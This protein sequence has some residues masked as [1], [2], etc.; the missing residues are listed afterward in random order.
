MFQRIKRKM[1]KSRLRRKSSSHLVFSF[2]F[3]TFIIFTI[4]IASC[5]QFSYLDVPSTSSLDISSV[6]ITK[7]GVLSDIH[8]DINATAHFLDVFK[9]EGVDFI[10]VPG[11]IPLNEKLRYGAASV[12][13]GERD[14]EE[15]IFS[16]LK[17]ISGRNFS[18]YVIPGNHESKRAYYGAFS[19]LKE[20]LTNEGY[21]RVKDM[22]YGGK[23]SIY[24]SGN[25]T[26]LFDVLDVVFLPGYYVNVT[27]NHKFL[28]DDGFFLS[29]DDMK[30]YILG[31]NKENIDIIVSHGPPLTNSPKGI[32]VLYSGEHVGSKEMRDLIIANKIPLGIFGHIHEASGGV[33]LETDSGNET[34]EDALAKE[35]KSYPLSSE[36]LWINPGS[37]DEGSAGIVG[38]L[39]GEGKIVL[40]GY[41]LVS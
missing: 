41:D 1:L 30:K 40:L 18:A 15:E 26:E 17:L 31:D 21:D 37:V 19:R 13:N 23:E 38:V 5:T 12:T 34:I 33:I 20:S 24:L 10:I 3:I 11:D 32:D 25:D 14:D 22:S 35:G 16:I 39:H 29:Y 2:V 7:I 8:G 36:S 27:N 9:R 28:T 4:F 6:S